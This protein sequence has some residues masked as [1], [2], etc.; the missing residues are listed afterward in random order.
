MRFADAVEFLN[1]LDE[2]D[3]EQEL[4]RSLSRLLKNWGIDRFCFASHPNPSSELKDILETHNFPN[5]WLK[6]YEQQKY[7]HCDVAL[8]HAKRVVQPFIYESAPDPHHEARELV[9]D[10]SDIG[11]SGALV[12]PVFGPTGPRG[13]AWLQGL[14][15]DKADDPIFQA[16]AVYTFERLLKFKAAARPVLSKRE[17]EVLS[18]AARGKSAWEIGEILRL[19]QGTVE[20][21]THSASKKLGAANRT[22]AIVLALINQLI[23]P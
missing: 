16:I 17:L 1:G 6:R 4:N 9:G 12:V 13:V 19:A 10:L 14:Q 11:L 22:H 7:L 18:W 8:R 21:Y 3:D 2:F 20:E 15:F 5:D 23:R